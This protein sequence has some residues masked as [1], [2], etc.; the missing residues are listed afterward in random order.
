MSDPILCIGSVLWDV[1][2]RAEHE[3][4]PGHDSP[5]RI[6]RQAGGVAY[7]VGAALTDQGLAVELLSAVGT[8]PE[9][10]L[11]IAQTR[12][13][14]IGCDHI[15]RVNEPTDSYMALEQANGEVFGA[16][17]DCY[18]LE[19]AGAQILEPL[20]NGAIGSQ[21]RPFAGVVVV[22]GNLPERVLSTMCARGDLA[23]AKTVFVPASPGKAARLRALLQTERGTVFVN[24][25]EAEILC[26]QRFD[27][28]RAAAVALA[29]YGVSAIVTDGA[30]EATIA[31]DGAV[32]SVTPPEVEV[33]TV[34]GAGDAFLAG[35]LVADMA[36]EHPMQAMI[37][38]ADAAARHISTATVP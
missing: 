26:E 10:D 7:N 17:A 31:I 35:Y 23:A 32:M 36:G 12:A 4:T 29:E 6:T 16:V 22:D 25:I 5:G 20:T 19:W 15:L 38:A 9:G 24:R 33:R 8:D 21:A 18:T 14:G 13:R 11:L 30:R 2:A 1:I 34:T 37:S 27:D 28:S 3:M